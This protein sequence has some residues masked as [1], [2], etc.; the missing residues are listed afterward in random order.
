MLD[1]GM[2]KWIG[3][4]LECLE[5]C[6]YTYSMQ[7]EKYDDKGV[8]AT[9]KCKRN[10]RKGLLEVM[11]PSAWRIGEELAGWKSE[12]RAFQVQGSSVLQ[13]HSSMCGQHEATGAL[14]GGV[15]GGRMHLERQHQL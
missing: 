7:C 10:L 4:S 5:P 6:E 11:M 14:E 8:P 13:E 12:G 15:Q 1:T 9:H 3:T 2:Q